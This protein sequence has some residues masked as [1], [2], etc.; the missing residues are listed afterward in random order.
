MKKTLKFL[1][2]LIIFLIVAYL[3]GPKPK[4]VILTTQITEDNRNLLDIKNDI[5][6]ENKD[7][8]IRKGNQSRLIWADSIPKKTK[9]A[10]VYLHGFSASPAES[11]IV[12]TDIAKRYG[13]NLY[14]PRLYKHGLKDKEPLLNFT[15]KGY[16]DSA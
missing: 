13:A 5:E 8:T 9:Y 1:S 16:F 2:F 11:E 15:A 6:K 14:A 3:L 10:I 4:P 12:Y 7:S